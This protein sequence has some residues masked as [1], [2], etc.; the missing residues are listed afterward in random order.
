MEFTKGEWKYI[1]ESTDYTDGRPDCFKGVIHGGE[2]NMA[3]CVMVSDCLEENVK[4]NA[5]LISAA[6]DMYEALKELTKYVFFS[7]QPNSEGDK[8]VVK[9]NQAL[10]KA[11][12]KV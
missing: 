1:P 10:N 2:L 5:N 7:S 12:G 6:P 8:L 9:A 3:I 4:A 11:E